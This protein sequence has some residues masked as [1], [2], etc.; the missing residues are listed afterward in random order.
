MIDNKNDVEYRANRELSMKSRT[1]DI[2]A[3]SNKSS[4]KVFIISHEL[5]CLE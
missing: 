3:S 4:N 1:L 2:Y 5:H